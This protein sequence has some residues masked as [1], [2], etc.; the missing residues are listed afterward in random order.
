MT[1]AKNKSKRKGKYKVAI[2]KLENHFENEHKSQNKVTTI[3][4][5][6]KKDTAVSTETVAQDVNTSPKRNEPVK[7]AE[8]P[9]ESLESINNKSIESSRS[10]LTATIQV[11]EIDSW[12]EAATRAAATTLRLL[13]LFGHES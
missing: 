9:A 11:T 8:N 12:S 7:N 5:I 6:I 13:E 10:Q 4:P 3:H 2:R 1:N